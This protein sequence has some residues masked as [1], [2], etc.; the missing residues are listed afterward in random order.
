MNSLREFKIDSLGLELPESQRS[1]LAII[2]WDVVSRD[3]LRILRD[4]LESLSYALDEP[5][6]MPHYSV[7]FTLDL[8]SFFEDNGRV[9]EPEIDWFIYDEPTQSWGLTD[10]AEQAFFRAGVL[11]PEAVS[12]E[13]YPAKPVLDQTRIE[14]LIEAMTQR[15]QDRISETYGL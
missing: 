5:T 14:E 13:P 11:D 1:E 9:L 7:D 2:D 4:L 12:G 15:F 3:D 8:T 6:K 10:E